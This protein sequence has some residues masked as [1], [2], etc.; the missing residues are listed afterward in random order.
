M[1][2]KKPRAAC[3]EHGSVSF[4]LHGAVSGPITARPDVL[5]LVC[6][7]AQQ[8]SWVAAILICA[9][10]LTVIFTGCAAPMA[11]VAGP[12]DAFAQPAPALPAKPSVSS[13]E[14]VSLK[15]V[16]SVLSSDKLSA[17]DFRTV[18][19]LV[20][21]TVT[22]GQPGTGSLEVVMVIGQSTFS[23][24]AAVNQ[25][26]GLSIASQTADYLVARG[27]PRNKVYFDANRVRAS[28]DPESVS[29]EVVGSRGGR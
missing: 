9:A 11:N 10:L 20:L 23:Q 29:I 15:E 17:A 6:S 25:R 21:L 8:L 13:S 28:N 19:P 5:C 26:R 1:R 3:H 16:I 18:E 12:Q 22:L 27:V 2:T 4:E 14:R 7:D 24:D